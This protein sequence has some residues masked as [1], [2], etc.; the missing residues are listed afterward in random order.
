MRRSWVVRLEIARDDGGALGDDGV[1]EL[2]ELLASSGVDPVLG[3]GDEGTV[4]VQMTVVA[5]SDMAARSEAERTLRDRAQGLWAKLGLPPFTI[6][7][8]DATQAATPS[9]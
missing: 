6:S 4:L 3:L 8:V 5:T 9:G 1:G 7:F 2:T